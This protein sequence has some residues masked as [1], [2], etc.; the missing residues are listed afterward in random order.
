VYVSVGGLY[1]VYVER[2]KRK[3]YCPEEGTN[4][5]PGEHLRCSDGC[6]DLHLQSAIGDIPVFVFVILLQDKINKRHFV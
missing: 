2:K 5:D 3:M 6:V 4:P 1:G